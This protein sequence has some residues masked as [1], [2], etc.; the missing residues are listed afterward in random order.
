[1]KMFNIFFLLIFSTLFFLVCCVPVSAEI[2][3]RIVAAVNDEIITLYELNGRIKEITGTDPS[4]LK[5]LNKKGFLETR[6]N[7]LDLLIDEKITHDKVMELGI[8]A[9][10]KE[11]DAAI[12]GIKARN[13][14]TH[15]DMIEIISSDGMTYE[16]YRN[17]IKKEMEQMRL[18]DFEV[19]SK[20]IIS[21]EDIKKYYDDHADGFR[22]EER[23]RLAIILLTEKSQSDQAGDLSLSQ[24]VEDVVSR[25]KKGEDFAVL[26]KE[27]SQGPGAEDGGDLGFINTSNLDPQ[28]KKLIDVMEVGRI[29]KPIFMPSGVQII[30]LIEKYDKGLKS[31]EEVKGYIHDTLYREELNK[32]FATWIQELRKTAFI[33]VIF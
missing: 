3:N 31:L 26:A 16:K 29:S 15:E 19:K 25:L 22:S 20:I 13:N 27:Y 11:L 7:I 33:K 21:D 4:Q 14:W 1:M 6:R 30:K 2:F 23:V 24:R 12:E 17:T 5:Q 9:T 18:I 32:R 28:L 10:S 8:G